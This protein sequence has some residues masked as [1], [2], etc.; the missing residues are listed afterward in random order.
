MKVEE[1]KNKWCP[2]AKPYNPNRGG[3]HLYASESE[4]NG[5][6]SE[7]CMLWTGSDCRVATTEKANT[8]IP[9]LDMRHGK[10]KR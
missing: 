7:N 4:G 6:I 10:K 5:C 2:F 8:N 1:A 9:V 3:N